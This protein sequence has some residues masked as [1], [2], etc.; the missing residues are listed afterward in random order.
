MYHGE[1]LFAVCLRGSFGT[2]IVEIPLFPNFQ[3]YVKVD[4]VEPC[5][6]LLISQGIWHQLH[7]HLPQIPECRGIYFK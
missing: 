2:K 1:Q 3:V 5:R 6:R 4:D 7:S